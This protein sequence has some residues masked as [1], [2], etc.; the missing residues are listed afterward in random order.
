MKNSLYIIA[1]LLLVIWGI[2]YWGFN[3]SG[4]VHLLL[5]VAGVIILVRLIFSKQLANK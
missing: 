2:I 4:A 3:A 5:A 1:V